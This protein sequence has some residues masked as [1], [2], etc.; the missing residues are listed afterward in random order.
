MEAGCPQLLPTMQK[1][2]EA[3]GQSDDGAG[4]PVYV[5]WHQIASKTVAIPYSR[6]SIC[7]LPQLW[8]NLVDVEP[9][10]GAIVVSVPRLLRSNVCNVM[11]LVR[12]T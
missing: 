4:I 8:N 7:R 11:L 12:A 2:S 5:V 3:G 9:E 1:Y 6:Q 10:S